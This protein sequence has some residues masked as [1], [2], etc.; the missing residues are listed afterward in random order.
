MVKKCSKEEMYLFIRHQVPRKLYEKIMRGDMAE[1]T[2][3]E[4]VKDYNEYVTNLPGSSE[5][6]SVL[7]EMSAVDSEKGGNM[8][9]GLDALFD[10]VVEESNERIS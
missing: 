9:R 5:G 3:N 8:G 2:F 4:W 10:S 6:A 7:C 1:N